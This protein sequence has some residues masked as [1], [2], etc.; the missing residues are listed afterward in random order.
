M[1]Q[2]SQ[3]V[4]VSLDLESK[5]LLKK[6]VKS[7]EEGN[8][9]RSNTMANVFENANSEEPEPTLN[10]DTTFDIATHNEI[11]LALFDGQM[12][13]IDVNKLIAVLQ[14]KNLFIFK[15]TE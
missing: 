14:N 8:R 2:Q 1:A 11:Q 15:R 9:N 3:K 6:I 4:I 12:H 5:T 7:L 10:L 13:T